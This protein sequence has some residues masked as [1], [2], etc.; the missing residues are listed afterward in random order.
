M[1]AVNR[2]RAHP[3]RDRTRSRR[4][5]PGPGRS[6]R[7]DRADRS[8][9][10]GR[11]RDRR[12]PHPNPCRPAQQLHGESQPPIPSHRPRR[13]HRRPVPGAAR[14]RPTSGRIG[15]AGPGP[16]SLPHRRGGPPQPGFLAARTRNH[17]RASNLYFVRR[18][19]S[20]EPL[21]LAS[22]G[23]GLGAVWSCMA[24]F[25]A[26]AAPPSIPVSTPSREFKDSPS[27]PEVAGAS[28]PERSGSAPST[29]PRSSGSTSGRSR[30]S[31]VSSGSGSPSIRLA[32]W[33]SSRP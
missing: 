30:R 12:L 11:S 29:G 32:A 7:S 28:R 20:G 1:D 17:E 25:S 27:T 22:G 33:S 24:A 8:S 13:A 23:H 4:A 9:D 21:S 18:H 14:P 26:D 19:V 6:G 10:R 5:N 15:L 3:G 16:P 31:A 2:A